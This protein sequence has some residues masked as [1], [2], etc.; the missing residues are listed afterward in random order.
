M[1]FDMKIP[2]GIILLNYF[3]SRPV[4]ETV[5][6][7]ELIRFGKEVT[8]TA[9]FPLFNNV[10]RDDLYY[11]ANKKAYSDYFKTTIE[12]GNPY[13]SCFIQKIG[14][15][16]LAELTCIHNNILRRS[17]PDIIA[18]VESVLIK[19]NMPLAQDV[20][21][22]EQQKEALEEKETLH[23]QAK[24]FIAHP[25]FIIDKKGNTFIAKTKEGKV[26][27]Q[28]FKHFE[29][30]PDKL[31]V[32]AEDQTLFDAT[33]NPLPYAK[34][35]REISVSRDNPSVYKVVSNKISNPTYYTQKHEQNQ[36]Q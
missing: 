28:G 7:C 22:A 16:S 36:K 35:V 10:N 24:P 19:R 1:S 17:R 4:G 20:Y 8:K 6:F 9:H 26:F 18:A 12:Y 33:G 13:N 14:D 21:K 30:M 25:N 5:E 3:V 11:C 31:L 29:L 23:A 32:V 2:D 15:K 34:K 27:A